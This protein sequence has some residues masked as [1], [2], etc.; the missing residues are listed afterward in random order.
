M[1]QGYGSMEIHHLAS[2]DVNVDVENGGSPI[3]GLDD[4]I[5]EY[6]NI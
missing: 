4:D 2:L 1:L 5:V 6:Q 3:M